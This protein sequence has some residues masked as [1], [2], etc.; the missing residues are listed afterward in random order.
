MKVNSIDVGVFTDSG[1]AHLGAYLAALAEIE[2]CNNVV[3]CDPSGESVAAARMTLGEKL[4][5]VYESPAKVLAAARPGLGVVSVEAVQAPPI[6]DQLL[7]ADCHVFAEKP[8]CIRSEDFAPLVEKAKAGNRHLMLALAN[9]I[10]PSVQKAKSLVEAGAIGNLYGAEI[11]LVADQTRL[12]RER[13]H[14]SW[15]ADR[16][17]AGGGHLAWLGLHWL[18]LAMHITGR[19]LAE[20]TGFTANVGGQPIQIEDAAALALRFDNGAL[21]TM[22][23]G[24]YLDKGYH[25]H[26]RLWGSAGWIEYAEWLG[27][28]RAPDPLRWYSHAEGLATEGIASYEGP[29]DPRGYTPWLRACVRAAAGLGEAPISGGEGLRIL[30]VV[31]GAYQSAES[32][33][34]VR[35]D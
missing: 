5:G 8:A 11:H 14:Q 13:Y 12:T 29:F 15:F 1:G 32:G 33:K 31:F 26:L 22:T 2:E 10:T 20:V 3:L 17:R 23:S 19:E 4:A 9:R 16:E 6:I 27:T 18:D 25:S 7:E 35:L 21:G 28:E 30:N 34:A 24:Y